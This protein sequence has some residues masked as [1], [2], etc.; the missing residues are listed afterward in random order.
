MITVAVLTGRVDRNGVVIG[1]A[2]GY[3]L[4]RSSR[5]AWIET[6]RTSTTACMASVAVLTGRVDRN[7]AM[8]R[9][10]SQASASR[11]SRAA[12]IETLS[13]TRFYS[14]VS[15]RSSRA[16]W[17]ETVVKD[18]F[19]TQ[20]QVA[21]L[22]G[23]V[24]RNKRALLAMLRAQVAVLTGRVD[25]NQAAIEWC[26]TYARRGPH[27]P[28]GSK[29]WWQ[30]HR[31]LS[32]RVAVLTGRVDRNWGKFRARQPYYRSRSSRAAWIETSAG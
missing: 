1:G 13:L 6:S 2:I 28:R 27:G 10:N 31:D 22:T 26:E 21:V 17:I 23:R 20:R 11:S 25:R 14:A 12:W 24:D 7:S 15:S 5:A 29:H 32:G 19:T 4:S 18:S 9:Q 3:V 16:A 8:P 30:R